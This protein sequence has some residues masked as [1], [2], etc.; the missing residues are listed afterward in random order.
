MPER[1]L[2]W[3]HEGNRAVRRGK[4]KLVAKGQKGPWELYDMEMDRGELTDL[5]ADHPSLVKKLAA[6]Y[7]NWAHRAR[8]IPD[9]KPDESG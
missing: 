6:A 1:T 3:E 4:W 7:E 9:R 2:Y 5:S 8:V